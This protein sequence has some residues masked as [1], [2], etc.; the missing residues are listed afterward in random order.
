MILQGEEIEILEQSIVID[1]F[2]TDRYL[3]IFRLYF[4]F[5]LLMK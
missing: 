3:V 1:G 4:H 2:K 5:S